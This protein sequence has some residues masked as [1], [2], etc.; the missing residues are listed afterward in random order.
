MESQSATTIGGQ[1]EVVG[2]LGEG[3]F[4]KVVM[5]K[6]QKSGEDVALKMIR[7]DR[8]SFP[9]YLHELQVSILVSGHENVIHTHPVYVPDPDHFV[10]SQELATS[11][12]LHS[13][14]D[15]QV[16][17]PE[18]VVKRCA[19]Q[20]ATALNY[21]H[22]RGIVHGDLKPDN[23]LL[24]DKDCH[25]I[26]LGDFGHSQSIGSLVGCMSHIIPYMS[27]EICSLKSNECLILTPSV[28]VW[29][30][31][32]LL[33]VALTGGYSWEKAMGDDHDFSVFVDWQSKGD[34]SS[35][36]PG[37]EMFTVEAMDMFFTLLFQ[38]PSLR[39]SNDH[40]LKYL[41]YPW[42]SI[43]VSSDS[44]EPSIEIQ[45]VTIE[46]SQEYEI[47]IIPGNDEVVI[48]EN[49]DTECVFV[50]GA[51]VESGDIIYVLCDN[52]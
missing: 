41:N 38:N 8:T 49:G 21:M 2:I 44:E 18:D 47:I 15:S 22:S 50:A 31:G 7:K 35:P 29:A 4:G 46:E 5:A 27:P 25:H 6:D 43:D 39:P 23:V 51:A 10:I 17:I 9:A 1:Y 14:I 30:F 12:T 33:Y 3:A 48:I 37:W 52:T 32:I 13:I 40:V 24:M 20:L 42:R 19:V 11:G 16:G 26:K 36:P 28:D 45:E 34:Y